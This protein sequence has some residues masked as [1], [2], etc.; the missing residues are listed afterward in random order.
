MK[1][2][3]GKLKRCVV[4]REAAAVAVLVAIVRVSSLRSLAKL[5]AYEGACLLLC[6]PQE[7]TQT[8]SSYRESSTGG[9]Q[10][11]PN[12]PLHAA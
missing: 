12:L 3:G 7:A 2:S 5:L 10:S 11:L 1:Y 8:A 9:S 6:G 4:G